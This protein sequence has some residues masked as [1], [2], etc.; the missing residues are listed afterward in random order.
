MDGTPVSRPVILTVGGALS[1]R[2]ASKR[3][4]GKPRRVD[5]RLDEQERVPVAG[6]PIG[7]QPVRGEPEHFRREVLAP[8]GARQ[9]QEARVVRDPVQPAL[10]QAASQPIQR[11]RSAVFHAA[12]PQAS[13][14]THC[15]PMLATYSIDSPIRG[16]HPR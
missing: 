9:D 1:P 2:V 5:K 7:T 8:G 15:G 16:A 11:S 6:L 14:A 13:N 10:A 4:A 12:P 3:R